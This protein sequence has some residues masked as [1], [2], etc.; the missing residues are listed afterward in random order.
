M[1]TNKQNSSFK[2]IANFMS[3][4]DNAESSRIPGKYKKASQI[5]PPVGKYQFS[6]FANFG[7]FTYF[8]QPYTILNIQ[9]GKFK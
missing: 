3:E 2:Y 8:L 1:K 6:N 7:Q 9:L 4:V 5:Q